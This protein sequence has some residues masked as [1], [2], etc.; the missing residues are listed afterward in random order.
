MTAFRHRKRDLM[1]EVIT[2]R[3]DELVRNLEGLKRLCAQLGLPT[4][5]APIAIARRYLRWSARHPQPRQDR[6]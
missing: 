3:D 4:D 5:G 6:R 1:G 2:F